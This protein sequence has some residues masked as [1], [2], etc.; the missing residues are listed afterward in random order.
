MRWSGFSSRGGAVG[1]LEG[2]LL[3]A[4]PVVSGQ[5]SEAKGLN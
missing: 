1:L 2:L 5:E 3:M 4:C